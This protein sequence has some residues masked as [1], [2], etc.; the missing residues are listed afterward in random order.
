MNRHDWN[1]RDKVLVAVM[2]LLFVVLALKSNFY[3]PYKPEFGEDLTTIERYISETYDGPLYKAG[4]LKVRLIKYI[5]SEDGMTVK[6]RRYVGG[7]FP[8]GDIYSDVK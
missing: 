7:V 4:L 6:L 8:I 1:V 5:E 3:D 2:I